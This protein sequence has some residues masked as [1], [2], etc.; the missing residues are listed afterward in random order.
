MWASDVVEHDPVADGAYCMLDAVETLAVNA[1]LFDL[2]D[3]ALA[4]AVLLR[5][6]LRYELMLQAAA[7]NQACVAVR[8]ED[9]AIV[10]TQKELP[11]ASPKVPNR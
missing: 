2:S 4:L 1:L 7:A 10:V 6:V 9:E 11:G 8:G 3:F 5:T